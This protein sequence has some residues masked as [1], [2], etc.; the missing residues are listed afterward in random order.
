MVIRPVGNLRPP[1]RLVKTA[2][3]FDEFMRQELAD[4][5]F[6]EWKPHGFPRNTFSRGGFHLAAT[7]LTKWPVSDG[8]QLSRLYIP[9]SV[10]RLPIGSFTVVEFVRSP[11]RA[12]Q[13]TFDQ[14]IH[15]FCVYV[16]CCLHRSELVG[17]LRQSSVMD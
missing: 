3:H 8:V 9:A 17:I 5:D 4:K 6:E 2:G 12:L 13:C 15:S 11:M 10:E 1:G 14:K 16:V 7:S